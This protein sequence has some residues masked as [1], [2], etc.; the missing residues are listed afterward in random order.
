MKE[1]G[2]KN[3]AIF[4]IVIVSLVLETLT[5]TA[6][7]IISIEHSYMVR[8]ILNELFFFFDELLF[9]NVV[10]G[11]IISYI[12]LLFPLLGI[13]G[14]KKSNSL[15]CFGL[16]YYVFGAFILGLKCIAMSAVDDKVWIYYAPVIIY[17]ITIIAYIISIINDYRIK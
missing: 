14:I 5:T 8:T 4:F 7:T 17:I 15:K 13:I 9:E 1:T 6:V 3:T 11:A 2:R 12:F 16:I 10:Q